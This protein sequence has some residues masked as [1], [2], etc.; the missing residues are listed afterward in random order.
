GEEHVKGQPEQQ[1]Q[2]IVRDVGSGLEDAAPDQIEH[3]EQQKG[4]R[5]RPEVSNQG[6]EVA[7]LEVR[8]RHHQREVGEPA[9]VPPLGLL[10]PVAGFDLLGKLIRGGRLHLNRETAAGNLVSS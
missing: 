8:A 10:A 3:D 5:E 6:V 1:A 9:Y 7:Q 2:L 4:L